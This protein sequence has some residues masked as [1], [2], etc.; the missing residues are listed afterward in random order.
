MAGKTLTIANAGAMNEFI[1]SFD[2][3]S[4]MT[5]QVY[6][7]NFSHL[8]NGVATRHADSIDTKFFVD[9]RAVIVGLAQ[10]AF[11]DF[12]ERSGRNLTDREAS[13]IAAEYLRERLEEEDEHELYDVP[14]AEVTRLI[15]RMKLA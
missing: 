3:P 9:G 1:P 12:R 14:A 13:Y 4:K 8:W 2:V 11:Y 6:H 7:C 15:G 5:D 10:I